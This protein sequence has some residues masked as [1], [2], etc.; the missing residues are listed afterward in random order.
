M[1]LYD[2]DYTHSEPTGYSGRYAIGQSMV[3]TI[4]VINVAVFL[5][6][7][8]FGGQSHWIARGLAATGNSLVTPWLWWQLLTSGFV[9]DWNNPWHLAGNMVGLWFLGRFVEQ[10]LGRW[11]FLRF[12]LVAIVV[13]SLVWTTRVCLFVDPSGWNV[14]LL[15][16]S[17]AVTAV[18]ILFVCRFPHE[19]LLLFFTIPV[20][21]W[22]VGVIIVGMDMLG[23]GNIR[24]NPFGNSEMSARVAYDVHLAG[25]AFAAIYYYF[26][27]NFGRL[28]PRRWGE[29]AAS[30]SQSLR[31]RPNLRVHA[32]V[33]DDNNDDQYHDLDEEADRILAKI[34]TQGESSLT[35]AERRTLEAYSRRMRQKLR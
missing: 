2:R 32:P 22:L 33:E 27:I 6:D 14:P 34:G 11:E 1:G 7:V 15:G 20:P 8:L 9:H 30:A 18:V 5:A 31:S 4:I 10:W 35:P 23:H 12:Y 21:A 19:K 17:G 3:V 29:I 25:A 26:G 28:V 24:L 13:G 16:A